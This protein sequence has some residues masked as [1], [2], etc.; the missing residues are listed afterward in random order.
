MSLDLEV[1]N[2]FFKDWLAEN[3]QTLI[4]EA[5]LETA[6]KPYAIHFHVRD[7]KEEKEAQPQAAEKTSCP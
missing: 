7:G 4:K 5:L 3:Y 6:K 2:K 1:P